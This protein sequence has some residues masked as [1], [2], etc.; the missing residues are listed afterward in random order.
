MK[1][2]RLV[3]Y[4]VLFLTLVLVVSAF[5]HQ[6]PQLIDVITQQPAQRMELLIS[7][8][9]IVFEPFIG[10][11]VFYLSANHPLLEFSMLFV[12]ILCGLFFLALLKYRNQVL[13]GLLKWLA[14][15]PLWIMLMLGLISV[16]VFLPLPNQVLVNHDPDAVIVNFH[17]HSYFSHDGILSPQRVARWHRAHGFDAFFLTEH[18]NHFKTLEWLKAQEQGTFPSVPLILCGQEY[19]GSNHI[20]L[21]G[22]NQDVNTKDMPDSTA[23]QTAHRQNGV[24]IV[25]HWFRKKPRPL[26]YYVS[27]G[28]D[29]FEIANQNE[30]IY[31]DRSVFENIVGICRSHGLI[32]VGGCDLHGYGNVCSVW[33][34]LQIPGWHGMTQERQRSSIMELVRQHDQSRLSVLIYKDRRRIPD[35]LSSPALTFIDYFLSLNIYQRTTWFFWLVVFWLAMNKWVQDGIYFFNRLLATAGLGSGLWLMAWGGYFFYQSKRVS[36]DNSIFSEYSLWFLSIGLAGAL[37]SLYQVRKK[38]MK[39]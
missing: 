17:S 30:G 9:R 12:W 34:V 29:G 5:F 26:E 15:I 39:I 25:A 37:Y 28:V 20:L 16:S 6:P 27:C 7:P 13:S 36:G 1:D 8:W 24:A 11:L 14:F 32:A 38:I 22:L 33:N 21:L 18:N 35:M 3:F 10:P 19:S 2:R 4:F 31:Y 23:V